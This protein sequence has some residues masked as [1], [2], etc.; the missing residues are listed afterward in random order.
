[1][2]RAC[3]LVIDIVLR[4]IS[5][6]SATVNGKL[7]TK[8]SKSGEEPKTGTTV[9]WLR[10]P[11]LQK[12]PAL[13]QRPHPVRQRPLVGPVLHLHAHRPVVAHVRQRREERRPV[14]LP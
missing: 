4:T 2:K 12:P 8:V 3:A 6:T 13:P 10:D 9:Y 5:I 14:H 7:E 1:M 11:L